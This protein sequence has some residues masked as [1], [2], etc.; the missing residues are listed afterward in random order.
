[1]AT[2]NL[3]QGTLVIHDGGANLLAIPVMD[4]DLKWTYKDVAPVIKN[5]GEL[6]NFASPVEE[7]T[8][9]QF[10]VLFEEWQ[11]KSATGSDPS[12]VDALKGIGGAAAWTSSRL[13]GPYCVDLVFTL[14]KPENPSAGEEN[15]VLTFADFHADSIDFAE[16]TDANKLTVKGN[17]LV[18][19]PASVRT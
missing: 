15:E 5:R 7:P 19:R 16:G 14:D 6:Y 2:R 9:M 12:V 13:D 18:T 3:R 8:E 1:M 11:G 4:G 10:T 17:A